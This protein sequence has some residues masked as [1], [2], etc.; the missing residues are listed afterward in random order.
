MTSDTFETIDAQAR[1]SAK[2]LLAQGWSTA[3]HGYDL[4]TYHGDLEALE[5]RLGRKADRDE[6]FELERMIRDYLKSG[7]M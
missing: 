5:E 1:Q 7:V 4:G 6:R 3:E 2:E